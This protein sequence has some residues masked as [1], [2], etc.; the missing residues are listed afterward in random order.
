MS[1]LQAIPAVFL[2]RNSHARG[3][4]GTCRFPVGDK[5]PPCGGQT[6]PSSGTN[7]TLVGDKR[8]RRGGLPR[9]ALAVNGLPARPIANGKEA[10]KLDL[11]DILEKSTASHQRPVVSFCNEKRIKS[12]PFAKIGRFVVDCTL[13]DSECADYAMLLVPVARYLLRNIGDVHD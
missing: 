7:E 8:Q 2:S 13:T 6:R 9:N 10:Q 5:R 12:Y 11:Y 1:I 3:R 4:P